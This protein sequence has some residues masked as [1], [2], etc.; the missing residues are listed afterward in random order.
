MQ[1]EISRRKFLQGSVA[2]SV[3]AA[4]TSA[5]SNTKSPEDKKTLATTKVSNDK[6]LKVIPTL[7]EMCVNK[8]A[9]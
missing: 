6:D 3:V 4:T 1:V 8:C 9:A 5:L 2:L 7:C